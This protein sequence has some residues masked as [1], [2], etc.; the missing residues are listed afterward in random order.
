MMRILIKARL[1]VNYAKKSKR[2]DERERETLIPLFKI[3]LYIII[4]T[5]M[6]L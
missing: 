4:D 6:R 5:I 3:L 1:S 2:E